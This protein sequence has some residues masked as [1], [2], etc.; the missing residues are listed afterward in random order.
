M[1][2]TCRVLV[3]TVKYIHDKDVVHRDIRPSNVL[4]T[5]SDRDRT[6]KLTGFGAACSVQGGYATTQARQFEFAA[7]EILLNKKHGKVR[8]AITQE[9]DGLNVAA[10]GC[11]S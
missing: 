7:P 2:N 5:S 6:L 1:R 11:L 4:L 8:N 10:G 3:E 9:G